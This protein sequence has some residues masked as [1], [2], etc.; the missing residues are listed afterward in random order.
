MLNDDIRCGENQVAEIKR[1]LARPRLAGKWFVAGSGGWSIFAI[2]RA[3]VDNVGFF[4]ENFFPAYFEDNDYHYR[5]TRI[6][7]SKFAEGEPSGPGTTFADD[8]E[9]DCLRT[10]AWR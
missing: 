8:P 10:S 3:C 4:D 5:L 1:Q 9:Q 7:P 6:D 2:N